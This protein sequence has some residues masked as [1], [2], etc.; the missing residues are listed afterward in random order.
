MPTRI[1]VSSSSAGGP[2]NY[3]FDVNPSFYEASDKA[4]ITSVDILHG[5]PAHQKAAFDS[6]PRSFLWRGFEVDSTD[7]SAV[8]TYLR[9]VEGKIRYFNFQDIVSINSRWPSDAVADDSDWKKCRILSLEIVYRPGGKLKY[10]TIKLT[11]Q[12]EQ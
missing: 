8:V 4:D 9:S 3:T 2:A 12:P 1:G 10:D 11:V 7:I 6:R 5:A